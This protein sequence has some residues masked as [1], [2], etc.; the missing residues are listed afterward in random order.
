MKCERKLG[1]LRR[2]VELF[3]IN[4][5]EN[6]NPC[7]TNARAVLTQPK[8]SAMQP[9][10]VIGDANPTNISRSPVLELDAESRAAVNTER[11]SSKTHFMSELCRYRHLKIDLQSNDVSHL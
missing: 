4:K 10:I 5:V 8:K 2:Y 7:S 3:R 9:S 11:P 1:S 6:S